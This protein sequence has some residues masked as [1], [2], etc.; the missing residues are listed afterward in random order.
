MGKISFQLLD[1]NWLLLLECELLRLT[2]PIFLGGVIVLLI[3]PEHGL[4]LMFLKEDLLWWSESS[5]FKESLM[6]SSPR[7]LEFRSRSIVSM[8]PA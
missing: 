6:S 4:V 1:E 2:L 8:S 3:S 5:C 7:S